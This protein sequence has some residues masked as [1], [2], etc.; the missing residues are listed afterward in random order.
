M[1]S[2]TTSLFIIFLT[3]QLFSQELKKEDII[4][5][6]KVVNCQIKPKFQK[7]MEVG[8]KNLMELLK[9]RFMGAVFGFDKNNNFTLKLSNKNSIPLEDL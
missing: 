1:K 9:I 4:G 7:K 5:I 3:T 8:G 2:I 6:W